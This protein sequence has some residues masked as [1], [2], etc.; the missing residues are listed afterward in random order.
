MRVF[1]RSEIG[2]TAGAVTLARPLVAIAEDWCERGRL[3]QAY[4]PRSRCR[5]INPADAQ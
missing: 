1:W 4:E 2:A 3:A 5:A